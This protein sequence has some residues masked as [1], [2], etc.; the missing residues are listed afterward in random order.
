MDFDHRTVRRNLFRPTVVKGNGFRPSGEIYFAQRGLFKDRPGCKR[1]DEE[2]RP[3]C[4][5]ALATPS[6]QCAGRCGR[7]DDCRLQCPSIG[8]GCGLIDSASGTTAVVEGAEAA[9]HLC[10]CRLQNGASMRV[11]TVRI[12]LSNQTAP[13]RKAIGGSK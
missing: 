12:V 10:R 13:K 7:A 8:W 9:Q 1:H 5:K 3:G 11:I 6:L 4:S 2:R